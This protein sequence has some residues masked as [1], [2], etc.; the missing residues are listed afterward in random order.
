LLRENSLLSFLLETRINGD[1]PGV[2]IIRG[3]DEPVQGALRL[4]ERAAR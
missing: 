3:G 2:E 1:V 4:A